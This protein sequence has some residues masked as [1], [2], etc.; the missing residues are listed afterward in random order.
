MLD[1]IGLLSHYNQWINEKI[2]QTSAQLSSSEL[3]ADR[4]AFF[5]SV[6]GT[7]N[8]IMVADFLWLKRFANHPSHHAA[9]NFIRSIDKPEALAEILFSDLSALWEEREHLD[10]TIIDWCQ[11]LSYADLNHRLQYQNMKGEACVK[12]F[13]SLLLHFFNHQTHH[14]GQITTLLSQQGLDVGV[15][16]LVAMIPNC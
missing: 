2:Y 10:S 9:L 3:V 8:H 16:D 14:R 12:P 5:G 13:G 1:Y 7:L 4:G 11:Q 15:T 6:L